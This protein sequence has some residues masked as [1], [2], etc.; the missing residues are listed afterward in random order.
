MRR[1]DFI[2]SFGKRA[3]GPPAALRA[4]RRLVGPREPFLPP[5]QPMLKRTTPSVASSALACLCTLISAGISKP[6]AADA[7]TA[8]VLSSHRAELIAQCPSFPQISP[9]EAANLPIH[10]TQW[11][12]TGP[13]VIIVHGGEQSI[14]VIGGGPRNWTGQKVL[15]Q[16]GWQL[17]LPERP[18]FG[19]SPSRGPDDQIADAQWIAKMLEDGA[20]L[21]GHSFGGA[22][23]LLAAAQRPQAVQSLVLVEPDLWPM[24]KDAPEIRNYQQIREEISSKEMGLLTAK[25]PADYASVLL[26]SFQPAKSGFKIALMRLV[27]KIIP[28]LSKKI[29]CGALEAR[30]ATGEALRRAA[31]TVAEAHI[32]VL[33][34]TGGWSPSRDGLGD[35][36]ARLTGGHHVIVPSTNHIVMASNPAGF[37]EVVT[38][39][40][41]KADNERALGTVRPPPS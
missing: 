1:R 18:G 33:V 8:A 26:R 31:E 20:N 34:I 15:G 23:A 14:N 21:W 32:P 35:L 5:Q 19:S 10:V 39:F 38:N 3:G 7:A 11:G 13:R 2:A 16:R 41:R 4:L 28:G 40:M 9:A 37:N 22:D 25:T 36:A 6:S 30:E 12:A 24:A 17:M 27:V 29:G